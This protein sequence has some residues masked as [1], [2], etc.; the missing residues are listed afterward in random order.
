MAAIYGNNLHEKLVSVAISKEYLKHNSPFCDLVDD[1][2][3]AVDIN[4]ALD[5]NSAL[6]GDLDAAD[7]ALQSLTLYSSVLDGSTIDF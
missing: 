4:L 5:F 6:H 7:R 2:E 3:W 1:P